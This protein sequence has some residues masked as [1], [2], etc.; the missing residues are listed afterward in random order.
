MSI[1]CQPTTAICETEI[2][3]QLYFQN[4]SFVKCKDLNVKRKVIQEQLASLVQSKKIL[5]YFVKTKISMRGIFGSQT[6][7]FFVTEL[8]NI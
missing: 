7:I 1:F 3:R 4:L 8:F 2:F 6:E 5:E